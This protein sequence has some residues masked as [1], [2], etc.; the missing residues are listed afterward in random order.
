MASKKAP[1]WKTIVDAKAKR[2]SD[3][4][5]KLRRARLARDAEAPPPPQKPRRAV[6]KRANQRG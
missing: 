4:T 1:E 3:L 2:D 6:P 5:E